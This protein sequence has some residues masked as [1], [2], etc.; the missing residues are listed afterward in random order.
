MANIGLLGQHLD[1]NGF[2]ICHTT[3]PIIHQLCEGV[4]QAASINDMFHA[5]Q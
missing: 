2:C 5:H 1:K 3:V 4:N